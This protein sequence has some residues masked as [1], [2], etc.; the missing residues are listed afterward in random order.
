MID[1]DRR[2]ILKSMSDIYVTDIC[3]SDQ[4]PFSNSQIGGRFKLSPVDI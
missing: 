3:T 2:P 4:C 1:S